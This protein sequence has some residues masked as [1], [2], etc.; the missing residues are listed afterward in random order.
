[1]KSGIYTIT[2]LVNGKVYVGYSKNLE[3][4]KAK[5]FY[6]LRSQTHDNEYLQR[7]WNKYGEENFRYEILI[8]CPIDLLASEEHYWC[9]L[10]DSHNRD[11][12][13]NLKPTH[14]E[15]L[16]ACSEETKAKLSIANTGKKRTEETKRKL[17]LIAKE[18]GMTEEHKKKLAESRKGV[19]ISEEGWK[20]IREGIKNMVRVPMS[21]ETRDKISKINKGRKHINR[22]SPVSYIKPNK[23]KSVIQYDL[24]GNEVKIYEKVSAVELDG[25]NADLVIKACKGIKDSYKNFIW[26][27]QKH[28]NGC[29]EKNP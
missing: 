12:G 19:K 27:Y 4:R 20:R 26:R 9:N 28:N 23:R 5:H 15:K 3:S 17:S 22:K 7:A 8:E 29:G 14:P 11:R 25:F 18:R 24:L 13:Y 2:N 21:Q 1:M 16:S 6:E 10:L